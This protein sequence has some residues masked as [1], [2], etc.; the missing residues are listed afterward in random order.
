M[1]KESLPQHFK[2]QGYSGQSVKEKAESGKGVA[3]EQLFCE[4][5]ESPVI[6]KAIKIIVMLK[7][8]RQFVECI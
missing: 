1:C 8:L 2:V 5:K 6:S 4:P 7:N 3:G